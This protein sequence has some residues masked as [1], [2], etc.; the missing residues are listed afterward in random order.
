MTVSSVL[1]SDQITSLI[2]QAETA[3]Q[4]PALSLQAQETPIETQI[5]ALGK[6]QSALSSLQSAVNG[7]SEISSL[8]QNSVSTS[9]SGIVSATATN[10]AAPGAY[11]LTDVHPASAETL[12]SAGFASASATLGSGSIAIQVGSGSATTVQVA[13]GQSN[14]AGIANAIN[15]ANLGVQASVIYD[16]TS[17][18]LVLTGAQ[19]GAA[20]AFTVSGTGALA[21]LSY[22]AGASGG[23]TESE[24]AANAS[25][26][27]NGIAITS[28]SNTV[29]GVVPGLTFTLAASGSATVQVTQSASALDQAV[30]SFVSAINTVLA[31]INQYSSYSQASGAGPLLGDVGLQVLR[32]G[33]IDAIAA[34][35][36]GNGPYNS[37]STI[38]FSI[39]SG[40][41]VSFDD[42]SFQTA[43]QSNYAA[44]AALLGKAA[45]A[46]NA[47]VTVQ[48]AGA[49]QPGSYAVDVTAN[50]GSAVTGTVNGEAASG[51]GGVLSVFGAGPAQGLVLQIGA[52]IT[53]S[54]GQVT[55]SDGLYGSLSSLVSSALASGG[56]GVTGQINTLTA[57]ITSMNKQIAQLQQQAQQETATLTQQYSNAEATMTQ[58]ETVSDF[59]ATYFN[60]S[61]SGTGG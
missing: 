24:K 54:L 37:L 43:A 17:Y 52:G 15:Q 35:P 56:G 1:S 26:S 28:G 21:N 38:G 20:N 44:V 29:A 30:N 8:S 61:T 25:F 27:L 48:T 47:N 11:T 33:L 57:S 45:T 9:P 59:L 34:P 60:Q 12:F 42:S 2:Q 22:N 32:N 31:T 16:G 18:H 5:S 10:A 14:L 55:V 51:S 53:G 40:G 49:A 41:T 36:S 4:Q 13:G 46:S 3:Y 7:L 58:L 6:V 50:T 19:T 39:T 23:L